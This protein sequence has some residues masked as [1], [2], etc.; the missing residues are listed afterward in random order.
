MSPTENFSNLF[1]CSQNEFLD[2][3][4]S[5]QRIETSLLCNLLLEKLY[6][7]F[8]KNPVGD[9]SSRGHVKIFSR[10]HMVGDM[11]GYVH[12]CQKVG[13][14]NAKF[15]DKMNLESLKGCQ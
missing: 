9:K 2:T 11:K 7:Q 1:N 14:M 6:K 8:L 13:A 10:G 15:D 5:K 4:T 12:F 3:R